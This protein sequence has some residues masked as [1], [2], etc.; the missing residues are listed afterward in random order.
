MTAT[1]G[2]AT[3]LAVTVAMGRPHVLPRSDEHAAQV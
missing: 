1:H 3:G 2:G